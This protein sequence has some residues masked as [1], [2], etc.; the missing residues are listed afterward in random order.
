MWMCEGYFFCLEDCKVSFCKLIVGSEACNP[1][2]AMDKVSACC[3]TDM[4]KH[5][6]Y[7]FASYLIPVDKQ[8]FIITT[9]P[10]LSLQVM[11]NCMWQQ[12]VVTQW[13]KNTRIIFLV[14]YQVFET[15]TQKMYLESALVVELCVYRES[16]NFTNKF[17]LGIAC[18]LGGAMMTLLFCFFYW[19]ANGTL[20]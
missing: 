17:F 12:G 19:Q 1:W 16:L 20:L 8:I 9:Q 14:V 15:N 18:C 10:L 2:G 3:N 11:Y 4:S 6:G 7:I 13:S 5:L